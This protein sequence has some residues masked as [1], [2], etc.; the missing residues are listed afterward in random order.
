ML[1][2]A[3]RRFLAP[4]PDTVWCLQ[5]QQL[6]PDRTDPPD[7]GGRASSDTTDPP[8]QVLDD[9][10]LEQP[11]QGPPADPSG[12]TGAGVLLK[13]KGRDLLSSQETMGVQ[14]CQYG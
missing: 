3:Q 14:T 5:A 7:V 10:K 13:L 4:S 8:L 9:L 2:V 11:L 6:I 12:R 1:K